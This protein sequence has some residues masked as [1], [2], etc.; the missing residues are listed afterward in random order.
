MGCGDQ[1]VFLGTRPALSNAGD[2]VAAQH[3]LIPAGLGTVGDLD[4]DRPVL[5][6]GP[7]AE[8]VE[9]GDTGILRAGGTGDE[10]GDGMGL[11]G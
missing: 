9:D 1:R 2:G 7:A 8:A 5:L 3:G 11:G 6:D 4:I 10:I